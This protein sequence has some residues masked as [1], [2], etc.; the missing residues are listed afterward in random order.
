[1][2]AFTQL[3]VKVVS[4]RYS[5]A[6][7]PLEAMAQNSFPVASFMTSFPGF[8]YFDIYCFCSITKT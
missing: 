7:D 4:F 8:E 3:K 1:M 2:P 5:N 6:W